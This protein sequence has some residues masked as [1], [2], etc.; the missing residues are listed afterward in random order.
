MEKPE[1]KNYTDLV[2]YLTIRFHKIE[3][4][5]N[6]IEKQIYLEAQLNRIIDKL[7]EKEV[8]D[9]TDLKDIRGN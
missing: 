2:S 5:F 4:R 3:E 7:H 9:Y 6:T 8:F 1:V